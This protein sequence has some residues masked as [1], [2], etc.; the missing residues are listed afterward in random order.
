MDKILNDKDVWKHIFAHTIN[1]IKIVENIGFCIC[2]R[3]NCDLIVE[4]LI[5]TDNDEIK[6]CYS[7]FG[8]DDSLIETILYRNGSIVKIHC[9]YDFD[10]EMF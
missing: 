2:C 7:E 9:N 5:H 1:N 10:D 3:R 8:C 4:G 6:L